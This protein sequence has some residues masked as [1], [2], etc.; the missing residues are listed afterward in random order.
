MQPAPADSREIARFVAA[1]PVLPVE[2]LSARLCA[3]EVQLLR[4]TECQTYAR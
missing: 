1:P 2:F 4:V 3:E